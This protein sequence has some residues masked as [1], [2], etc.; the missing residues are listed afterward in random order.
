MNISDFFFVSKTQSSHVGPVK[1]EEDIQLEDN[2]S[3]EGDAGDTNDRQEDGDSSAQ[4]APKNLA[5]TANPDQIM[6]ELDRE[7]DLIANSEHSE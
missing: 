5:A 6:K 7:S 2:F 1:K 3:D 4:I